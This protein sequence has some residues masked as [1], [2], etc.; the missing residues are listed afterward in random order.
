MRAGDGA[1]DV[2]GLLSYLSLYISYSNAADDSFKSW[3]F[4]PLIYHDD[5]L[6]VVNYYFT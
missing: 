4:R 1:A 3:S 5:K 2:L 6:D